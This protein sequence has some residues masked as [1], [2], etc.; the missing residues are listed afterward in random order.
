MFIYWKLIYVNQ[1]NGMIYRYKFKLLYAA[2]YGPMTGY[3]S[4]LHR[5][6]LINNVLFRPKIKTGLFTLGSKKKGPGQKTF[7]QKIAIM[8]CLFR[9]CFGWYFVIFGSCQCLSISMY[10]LRLVLCWWLQ[11]AML[12]QYQIVRRSRA[13][14]PVYVSVHIIQIGSH[15]KERWTT[16]SSCRL[17]LV[18]NITKFICKKAQIVNIHVL[19]Q[20]ITFTLCFPKRMFIVTCENPND[21][22]FNSWILCKPYWHLR[23][24][25]TSPHTGRQVH[26]MKEFK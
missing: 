22:T 4:T 15:M 9:V 13:G 5:N 26:K 23:Q 14:N 18:W 10:R 16:R 25:H 1:V 12:N 24:S 21:V 11:C 7:Y 6:I 17:L 2:F 20:I 3:I 19:P 8:F